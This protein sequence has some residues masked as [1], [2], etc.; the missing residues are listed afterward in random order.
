LTVRVR[1]INRT[2]E[3]L[4]WPTTA[5]IVG[6]ERVRADRNA[7]PPPGDLLGPLAPRAQVRGELRFETAGAVTRQL[8]RQAP[9]AVANRQAVGDRALHARR[10]RGGLRRIPLGIGAFALVNDDAALAA[11]SFGLVGACLGFL[12]SNLA[13]PA[14]IFL[15]D[16]GSMSVG[17]VVAAMAIAAPRVADLGSEWVL[18]AALLTGLV[19]LDTTLVVISRRRRGVQLLTGGRDHLTHRLLGSPGRRAGWPGP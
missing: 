8:L 11:L 3:R 5:L 6:E 18:I 7:S 17:F 14:R 12:R 15:G 1:V 19:I 4:S 9:H 13:Q 10:R 16:G 2:D